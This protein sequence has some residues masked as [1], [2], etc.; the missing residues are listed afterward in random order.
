MD[1]IHSGILEPLTKERAQ[2]ILDLF[3]IGKD[4]SM[5]FADG[6]DYYHTLIVGEE[7]RGLEKEIIEKTP[8]CKTESELVKQLNCKWLNPREAVETVMRR[9][10]EDYIN[11]NDFK[12]WLDLEQ[13]QLRQ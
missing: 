12:K 6:Y 2:A 13:Q 7:F 9:S 8:N 4:E 10:M 3:K 5:V 11:F 1:T